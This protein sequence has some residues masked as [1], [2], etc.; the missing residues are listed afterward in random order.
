[1]LYGNLTLFINYQLIK[2]IPVFPI[3][4]CPQMTFVFFLFWFKS[5]GLPMIVYVFRLSFGSLI[6]GNLI[7]IILFEF[8]AINTK[9]AML[10]IFEL[11]AFSRSKK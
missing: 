10:S 8:F 9:L 2:L 11:K 7:Q 6:H 5:L 1:M 3:A 4:K